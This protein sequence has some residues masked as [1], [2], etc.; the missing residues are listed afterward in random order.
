MGGEAS[1]Y[2]FT[3]REWDADASLYYYRGRYYDASIGRFISADPIGLGGGVNEFL[4]VFGNAAT[5]FD[6][7]GLQA[8]SEYCSATPAPPSVVPPLK[9][10]NPCPLGSPCISPY[11]PP[12]PKPLTIG[13]PVECTTREE[14]AL[15][16]LTQARARRLPPLPPNPKGSRG[17]REYKKANRAF[18]G[19]VARSAGPGMGTV[20]VFEVLNK[21]AKPI[22]KAE[23]K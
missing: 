11:K 20:E 6:P 4:Y 23:D 15:C 8:T 9:P 14:A 13:D 22:C 5:L 12:A 21:C 7:S 19:T 2:A 1:G 16:V 17:D 10:P 18:Q 3:G